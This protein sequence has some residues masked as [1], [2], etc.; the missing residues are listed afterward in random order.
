MP[1]V[2]CEHKG[3]NNSKMEH[4]VTTLKAHIVAMERKQAGIVKAAIKVSQYFVATC[5]GKPH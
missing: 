5:H 2:T 3:S 4:E 1:M